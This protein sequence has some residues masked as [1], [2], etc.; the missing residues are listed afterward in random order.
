MKFA[1]VKFKYSKSDLYAVELIERFETCEQAN[2]VFAEKA[3]AD[4]TG[5]TWQEAYEYQIVEIK[6]DGLYYP[7]G[8]KIQTVLD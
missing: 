6:K 1:I 2:E 4:C 3:Y 8:G 5:G 7:D